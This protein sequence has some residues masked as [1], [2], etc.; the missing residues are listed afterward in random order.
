MPGAKA[1]AHNLK[2]PRA[3]LD[4]DA[5]AEAPPAS[6]QRPWLQLAV[7]I[8]ACAVDT[9]D[10]ALLPAVFKAIDA[11]LQRGPS[12]LASLVFAQSVSYA[13]ALPVWGSLMQSFSIRDFMVTGCISMSFATFLLAAAVEYETHLFLRLVV[14]ATLA[15]LMPLGQAMLCNCVPDDERGFAFGLLQSVCAAATMLT[16]CGATTIASETIV[17]VEG[18]RLAH[19]GLASLTLLA[20]AAVYALVEQTPPERSRGGSWLAQQREVIGKVAGKPSFYIMVGQGI[21]GAIPWNAFAF[22]PFYFQLSG[23]TDA[24]AGQILL[25]GGLGAVVGGLLGGRLG[26][27]AF[28]RIGT[29]GRC[30]VA[31]MS[32]S[33]GILLFVR[34]VYVQPSDRSFLLVVMTFFC[35][36]MTA[37]WTPPAALRPI[38]GEICT[39][40]Q[41]RAQVIAL[42]VAV[43][44]VA[45]ACFGAPVV[46][47][48]CEAFGYRLA[49]RGGAMDDLLP[50]QREASRDALRSALVGV[51]TV[52]WAACLVAWLPMYWTYPADR[53][54]AK[55]SGKDAGS[56]LLEPPAVACDLHAPG[57]TSYQ[58]TAKS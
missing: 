12:A 17:G 15:S 13:L 27:A 4:A 47:L 50:T 28:R 41:D 24:Q 1:P 22:L 6:R 49:E 36:Q 40:S 38:C 57:R 42:W 7:V 37:T 35:F 55:A 51:S 39:S 26:D 21:F 25:L 11:Q 46:G 32:V 23:Y 44:G 58:A 54:K 10:K 43:E 48:L 29:S 34:L 53:A 56:A 16:S 8:V 5:P 9:A 2:A 14:G 33:S 31:Q 52:C 19:V 20:G 18:W 3:S 30:L 45:S